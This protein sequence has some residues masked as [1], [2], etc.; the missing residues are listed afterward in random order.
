MKSIKCLY[1]RDNNKFQKQSDKPISLFKQNFL[2]RRKKFIKSPIVKAL[3]KHN[4]T[5]GVI[6][7]RTNGSLEKPVLELI[8]V[9][10]EG[11]DIYNFLNRI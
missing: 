3:R 7:L 4:Y 10:R 8:W 6:Y 9:I 5:M 11:R 1:I 2:F